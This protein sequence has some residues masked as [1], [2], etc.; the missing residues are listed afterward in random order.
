MFLFSPTSAAGF[1]GRVFP[2]GENR[3]LSSSVRAKEGR[4]LTP[5]IAKNNLG[6]ICAEYR[7][8]ILLQFGCVCANCYWLRRDGINSCN[9]L[10]VSD[11][12]SQRCCPF[13]RPRFKI[14]QDKALCARW[15]R[16]CVCV[17]SF[18]HWCDTRFL[19]F[20]SYLLIWYH[21]CARL[22]HCHYWE[23]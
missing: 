5:S 7:C 22:F 9:H 16:V 11:C 6:S 1:V 20:P 23:E 17:C 13:H 12:S 15:T 4:C 14:A 3:E 8:A 19:L 10:L 18:C 2:I 21:F